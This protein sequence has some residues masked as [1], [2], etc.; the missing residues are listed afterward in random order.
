MKNMP[1]VNVLDE[2]ATKVESV[3][4]ETF[5][6]PSFSNPDIEYLVGVNLARCE[7]PKGMNSAPCKHQYLL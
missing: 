7:C 5:K 6:V 1:P 3:G 2:I 4:N